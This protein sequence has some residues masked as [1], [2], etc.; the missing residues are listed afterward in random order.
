[1]TIAAAGAE[2]LIGEFGEYVKVIKKEKVEFENK[3][4][5]IFHTDSEEK[6][7]EE[8]K[9]KVRLY[10]SPSKETLEEYGFEEDT[11]ALM[12]HTEDIASS[13][14]TVLYEPGDYK[15]IVGRRSTNQIGNGPYLYIY[16]LIGT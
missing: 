9:R 2:T 4:D 8:S 10:T 14:D 12:Y 3:D 6:I 15:W 5:P 11:H 7:I 1:M 13:G 16:K